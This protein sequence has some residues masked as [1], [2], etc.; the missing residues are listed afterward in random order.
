MET[1]KNNSD[2]SLETSREFQRLEKI[3]DKPGPLAWFA[4][5]HVAANLL[6]LFLLIAGAISIMQIKIEVFPE[7]TV[8]M[9]YVQVPY[10]GATPTEVEQGVCLRV[11]EAIAGIEGIKTIR[12]TAS[13]GIATVIA[14][15]EEYAD[16]TTVLNEIK[17]EVDRI[18]TFP[19]ETEKP[20]YVEATTARQV[21]TM[22]VSGDVSERTLK[23]IADQIKDDLTAL[24]NI[25]QVT[26]SGARDYELSIEVSEETLRRY[27]LTFAEIGRA[28]DDSS[29]DLP[30]G[31]IDTQGGEILVRTRGQR[32][33]GTEFEEIVVLT[34]P[35]GTELK[36]ADIATVIDGFEDTDNLTRFDGQRA[37]LLNVFR[38][39]DQGALDV[40][41]T[42]KPSATQPSLRSCV[43]ESTSPPNRVFSKSPKTPAKAG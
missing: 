10:L 42:V 18:Q 3:A 40:S 35:D 34:Q 1:Q 23:V 33:A 4:G 24:D 31:S 36:L 9:V 25:S 38:V 41:S 14:E 8:D 26:I 12:S 13:E 30:A 39:G 20:W 32:Y 27:G 15:L 28:I 19:A 16:S 2:S 11:E 43:P 17:S 6:M 7:I 29:L 5:N 21:I 22:M 37:I